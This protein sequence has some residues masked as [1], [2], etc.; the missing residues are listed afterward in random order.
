[1]TSESTF[2]PFKKIYLV[3]RTE[4]GMLVEYMRLKVSMSGNMHARKI[5]I[6]GDFWAKDSAEENSLRS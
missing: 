6:D 4:V 1:M 5:T 2:I 3:L